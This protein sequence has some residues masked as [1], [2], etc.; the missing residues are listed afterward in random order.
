MNNNKKKKRESH[1]FN[2]N[3]TAPNMC[4]QSKEGVFKRGKV[5]SLHFNELY[6]FIF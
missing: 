5:Y 3:Q 4:Q 6:S 2:M 1:A